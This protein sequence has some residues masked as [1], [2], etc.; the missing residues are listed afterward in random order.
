[1]ASCNDPQ[2]WAFYVKYKDEP[3]SSSFRVVIEAQN[4]PQATAIARAQYGNL[5]VNQAGMLN[6]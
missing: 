4:S 5:L 2:K 3:G 6:G 1:M